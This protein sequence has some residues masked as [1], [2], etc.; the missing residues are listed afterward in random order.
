MVA[1]EAPNLEGWV[2]FPAT[3]LR[4]FRRLE[5]ENRVRAREDYRILGADLTIAAGSLGTIVDGECEGGILVIQWNGFD[6]PFICESSVCE[7]VE[8]KTRHWGSVQDF[9]VD[10]GFSIS[11]TEEVF[12]KW[13]TGWTKVTIPFSSLSG[14]DISYFQKKAKE[15]SWF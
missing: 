13:T 3:A 15:E 11:N 2:Q 10:I 9:L 1:C 6:H 14:K 12:Y 5:V 8:K 7:V 4:K